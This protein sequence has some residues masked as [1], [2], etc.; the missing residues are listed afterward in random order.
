MAPPPPPPPPPPEIPPPISGRSSEAEKGG[1]PTLRACGARWL[2][3]RPGRWLG[4]GLVWGRCDVMGM[5]EW[6]MGVWAGAGAGGGGEWRRE[7]E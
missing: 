4:F 1:E 3:P 6:G 7:G 2:A 5:G